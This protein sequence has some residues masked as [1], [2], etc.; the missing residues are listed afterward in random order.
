MFLPIIEKMN[1]MMKRKF[2]AP[3]MGAVVLGVTAYAGYRT[4]DAYAEKQVE[5][6]LLLENIEAFA[7]YGEI[8]TGWETLSGPC[9]YPSVKY[10]VTCKKGGEDDNCM[11]S[12]C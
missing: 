8:P 9:S 7:Q 10:W 12:D 1:I 2:F 4:Y 5:S 11:N 3:L 6:G